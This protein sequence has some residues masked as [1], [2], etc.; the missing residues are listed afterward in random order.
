MYGMDTIGMGVARAS[1][2]KAAMMKVAKKVRIFTQSVAW[3][4]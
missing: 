3:W 1:T 4:L 2:A